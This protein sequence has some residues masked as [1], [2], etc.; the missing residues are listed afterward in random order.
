MVEGLTYI[1]DL[2]SMVVVQFLSLF[3]FLRCRGFGAVVAGWS[4]G[5]SSGS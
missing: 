1:E 4:S 2:P 5:S 3:S